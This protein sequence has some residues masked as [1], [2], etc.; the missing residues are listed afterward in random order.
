MSDE[1]QA[2]STPNTQV[3]ADNKSD[4]GA[5]V[6]TP[7]PAVE[8]GATAVATPVIQTPTEKPTEQAVQP[9]KPEVKPAESLLATTKSPEPVQAQVVSADKL[10]LPE[11]SLVPKSYLDEIVKESKTIEEAQTKANFEHAAMERAKAIAITAEKSQGDKWIADITNDPVYGG[12]HLNE[13]DQLATRTFKTVFGEDE[14]K[15]F[16]ATSWAKKPG[17]VK[18]LA[19]LGKMLGEGRLVPDRMPPTAGVS[20]KKTWGQAVYGG[21]GDIADH[22]VMASR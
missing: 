14:F 22:E 11:N 4:S 6:A 13:T 12:T 9:A 10:K 17:I 5:K 21:K 15:E 1:V 16:A 7:A 3:S 2:V 8:S 18:G 20:E 19:K